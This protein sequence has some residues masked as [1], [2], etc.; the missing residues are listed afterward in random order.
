MCIILTPGADQYTG[1]RCSQYGRCRRVSELWNR[2]RKFKPKAP[3]RVSHLRRL[4]TS[5]PLS[6]TSPPWA[7]SSHSAPGSPDGA[8]CSG[9]CRTSQTP[10]FRPRV[11]RSRVRCACGCG[12]RGR[13]RRRDP[14]W[15]RAGPSSKGPRLS[16]SSRPSRHITDTSPRLGRAR[17]RRAGL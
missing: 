14:A 2:L 8:R 11:G 3:R 13:P 5:P 6:S 9:R 1:E 12:C 7:R 10:A 17:T 16:S 15:P 4:Q